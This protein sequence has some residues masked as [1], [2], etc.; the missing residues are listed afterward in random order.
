MIGY[1]AALI[2]QA[3]YHY[4]RAKQ[5]LD[6]TRDYLDDL[7]RRS[8]N[9]VLTNKLIKTLG[10]LEDQIYRFNDNDIIHQMQDCWGLEC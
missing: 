10:D 7:I 3:E 8:T 2:V 5:E 1:N 9:P 4:I 6:T